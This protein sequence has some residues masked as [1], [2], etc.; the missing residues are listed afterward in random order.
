MKPLMRNAV[1]K[2]D[3]RVVRTYLQQTADANQLGFQN[4][5]HSLESRRLKEAVEPGVSSLGRNKGPDCNS[6]WPVPDRWGVYGP[7]NESKRHVFGGEYQTAH[8]IQFGRIRQALD[9]PSTD[10]FIQILKRKQSGLV[11]SKQD[12][13]RETIAEILSQ[14]FHHML[15][16]G[17]LY[18]YVAAGRTLILHKTEKYAPQKLYFHL[19]PLAAELPVSDVQPRYTAAAQLATFA[20]L[21]MRSTE[22]S[23]DWIS[24]AEECGICRWPSLPHESSH[25]SLVLRPSSPGNKETSGGSAAEEGGFPSKAQLTSQFQPSQQSQAGVENTRNRGT[26]ERPTLPYCTQACLLGLA[27]DLDLDEN[28]PNVGMHHRGQT[29]EKH[30]TMKED[31]CSLINRQLANNLDENCECLDREVLFGVTGVL[32]KISATDYGYTFVPKGVQLPDK[33]RCD[34]EARV[35]AHLSSLQGMKVPVHLGNVTLQPPYPLVSLARVTQMM[36]MSWAG[37]SLRLQSWLENVHIETE[38]ERT[39]Q[40]LVSSGL[41]KYVVGLINLAFSSERQQ[42]MAYGFGL[43]TIGIYNIKSSIPCKEPAKSER[44]RKRTKQEMSAT[45]HPPAKI[46]VQPASST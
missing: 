2:P 41:N 20:I 38:K 28:C 24:E 3:E 27:R 10:L 23:R 11:D 35:Y 22:M 31:L 15:M 1:E 44:G 43:K 12:K 5:P 16:S 19:T 8:T 30:L 34:Y 46:H 4:C 9:F 36:L 39:L 26:I 6:I 37:E 21:S 14:A 29:C 17:I 25:K 33:P 32:Y 7:A 18:G 45:P 42:V 13:D 40:S